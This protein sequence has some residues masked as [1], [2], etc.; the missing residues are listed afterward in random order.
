MSRA[1]KVPTCRNSAL[2]AA[3]ADSPVSSA[4]HLGATERPNSRLPAAQIWGRLTRRGMS[5]V[6][7]A[8]YS[9]SKIEVAMSEQES[10]K[11]DPRG[12]SLERSKDDVLAAAQ[13][14]PRDED[15]LIDDLTEDEDRLFI[16]AVLDA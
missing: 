11:P 5:P 14:L 16:A 12:R 1:I 3:W 15:V 9:G 10:R 4:R 2:S 13:P 6:G 8:R 7:G